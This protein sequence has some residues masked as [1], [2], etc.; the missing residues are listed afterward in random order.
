MA[1][2]KK[3]PKL[4]FKEFTEVWKVEKLGEVTKITMGQSPQGINY[5]NNSEDHILVQ[6][7]ADMKDGHVVP[8]VWTTQVTK[9]ANWGDIIISVRAPVGEVGITDYEVVLGRGVAAIAGNSFIYQSLIRMNELGYWKRLSCG[10]TFDSINSNI[11]RDTVL[12]F[13]DEKE[14][15]QLGQYFQSFDIIIALHQREHEKLLEIEKAMLE[16]MFPQEGSNEPEIRFDGFTGKWEI[17]KL[18][19]LYTERNERGNNSLPILSVS[20]HHGVSDG[21]LDGDMLGKKVR[22][23]EDKSL[24]KHVYSGDLVFNMMRAWQGAIGVATTEGMVSPAYISAIPNEHVYPQFMDCSLSRESI[25]LQMNNLSYG[26]TD[27]RKRLY[28]DSFINVSCH[29]PSIAEQVKISD[30]FQHLN[31]LISLQQRELDKLKCIKQACLEK[32]FVQ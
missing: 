7:N 26:V 28:W 5:T 8:R 24:Y 1:K 15:I 10:S 16:K 25:I 32:M 13:P 9:T 4:R 30:F 14:Q 12:F 20:I 19:E 18:G 29:I 23:S 3:V 22:R 11:L 17:K 6:G 27:F 2:K 31:S 21:E